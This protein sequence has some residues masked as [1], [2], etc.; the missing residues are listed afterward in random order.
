MRKLVYFAMLSLDGF[1]AR[2]DGGLDW[3]KIDEELHSYVNHQSAQVGTY[4]YGRRMYELMA[5][6]WPTAD[7]DPSA[8]P[9]VVEFAALWRR[10]PKVVF[11]QTLPHVDWNATLER[12]DAVAEVARLKAESGPPLEVGGIGLAGSLIRHGLVDEYWLYLQP[13]VLGQ[14]LR[15]FPELAHTLDLTLLETRSFSSGV[16]HLQYQ[17][18]GEAQSRSS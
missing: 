6:D 3:V 12:G 2:P 15:L 1:I 11:S 17:G 8:P 13:V 10:I 4:L 14:G 16:V 5:R 9:S 7:Q 18:E